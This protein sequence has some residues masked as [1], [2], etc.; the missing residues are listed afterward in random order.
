MEPETCRSGCFEMRVSKSSHFQRQKSKYAEHCCVPLCTASSKYNGVLSFHCFP[1]VP[2]LRR[3]WLVNI[4][5]EKLLITSHTKVCSRHFS[6]DYLVQPTT[7]VGRMRLV[8]CAVPTLFQWNEYN[9]QKARSNVSVRAGEPSEPD[10]EDEHKHNIDFLM[11]HDYCSAPE[12]AAMDISASTAKDMPNKNKDPK[13]EIQEPHV[14]QEF[15]L[16]RLA[17]SGADDC[18]SASCTY[19]RCKM[20][21]SSRRYYCSVPFC[22]SNTQQCPYLSFHDFPVNID[23]REQWI[24]AIR[25]EEGLSFRVLR[26]S[27]FVCSQHFN[28]GDIYT[29][30]SGRIR[31]KQGAVPSRF[32]WNDFG[33]SLQESEYQHVLKR[34][35]VAN[36]DD[37][38]LMVLPVVSKIEVSL[39]AL[40]K[41]HNYAGCPFPDILD[42]A[43]QGIKD[44][45]HQVLTLETEIQQTVQKPE[46]L[47]FKVC[48]TDGDFQYYTRFSSMEVFIVF[49]ES[50]YPSASR[51]VYWSKA[52]QTV[53]ESS[54]YEKR[55]PL[56]DELFLFF[57][58]VAAGL[59]EKTLSAIF[60]V[61]LF[62]VN[63]IIL[64]WTNYLYLILGSLPMWMTRGQV[65]ATMPEE[66]KLHCPQVRVI[67]DYTEIHCEPAPSHCLQPETPQKYKKHITYKSM[68]GIAPC[69]L[70]TFVSKLYNGSLSDAVITKKSQI[71]E[72]L[73]PGDGVIANKCSSTEK[74]LSEVGATLLISPVENSPQ[75][76]TKD[77]CKTQAIARLR[78]LGERAIDRVKRYCLWDG[79]VPL[80]M[81]GSVN[82]LWTVCCLISNYQEP[83]DITEEKTV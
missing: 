27:T 18:V 21:E 5:R 80:S 10:P 71:L 26:G 58:R 55:L 83:L 16:Q 24:K 44:L 14:Q 52:Q 3:Q 33:S 32:H 37:P 38:Q 67:I 20:A 51:L 50:V 23:V 60:D 45:E 17:G 31:V 40:A 43:T 2:A 15:G 78:A 9:V 36:L 68:I 81:V 39:D 56:I 29:S 35:R 19:K 64:T 1:K 6:F 47:I 12:P 49:W 41:D 77:T 7:P 70:I 59:R 75:L 28:P 11:D 79:P 46:P 73:E 25:R 74:M 62:T 4:R 54:S 57:C 69:G 13:K 72:L 82:Q 22:S 42:S 63:H 65:Q 34:P 61:S 30:V 53:L 8:K 48:R 76:S 66:V